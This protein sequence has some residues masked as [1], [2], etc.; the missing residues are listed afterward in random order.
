MND[1]KGSILIIDD[2]PANLRLLHAMLA[3]A[4]FE[5]RVATGGRPA[6]RSVEA[7]APDLILLDI[8]MPDLSGY[9]VCARLKAL[10]ATSDIPVL[11]ISAARD[12]SAKVR[13]FQVGGADYICK[14]FQVEEVLAR[15]R[16]HLTIHAQRQRIEEQTARLQELDS[17]KNRLFTDLS[18]EFRTPLM[19][20]A[21]LIADVGDGVYGSLSN[22]AQRELQRA[23]THIGGLTT[24]VEQIMDLSRLEAGAVR[25]KVAP[26]D[27]LSFAEVAALAF[28]P[29]AE[30]RG[31]RLRTGG[32]AVPLVAWFDPDALGKVL[33]NLLA[34]ALKHTGQGGEVRVSVEAA[35]DGT[36]GRCVH[37]DNTGP[38]IAPEHLP[39]LFD[40]FYHYAP[41]P[42]MT[43]GFGIGLAL[44]RELMALHH[45][46]LLAENLPDYGVR[47]TVM[48]MPGRSHFT[49]EELGGGGAGGIAGDGAPTLSPGL[50]IL[51]PT[52]H[53]ALSQPA[54]TGDDAPRPDLDEPGRDQPDEDDRTTLLVV[55][56]HPEVRRYLR[57]HLSAEYAVIEAADGEEGLALARSRLPDLI[58]SDVEM[59]GMDGLALCRAVKEDAEIGFIPVILLTVRAAAEEKLEGLSVGAD[60]YLAK[61]FSMAELL[62]R[63]ANLITSRRRLMLQAGE[64]TPAASGVADLGAGGEAFS[65]DS[66]FVSRLHDAV[67]ERMS[68]PD[69]SVEDLAA[70]LAQDRTTLYRWLRRLMNQSPS[71]VI[72]TIRLRRAAALLAARAGTVS[73]VAYGVGFRSVQ[74]FDRL[75]RQAYGRTPSQYMTCPST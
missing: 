29:A 46:Q 67:T 23:G 20:A 62:A 54:P 55:D 65:A 53:N 57:T 11:F 41:Q 26:A 28:A 40:R 37:V 30:R 50:Q 45:G 13:S 19:L 44:S 31:V 33:A 21:G 61:P 39:H 70:A 75:F 42:G 2:E 63:V 34:N 7:E 36:G 9:E 52:R 27:V 22:E 25:L 66:L 51:L 10:P 6:L 60:D 24:L 5:V 64:R 17:L 16:H 49:D 43:R 56:D 72:R 69:F 74:H 32:S 73:E 1:H 48:L 4:G 15:V 68:D 59:P 8:D 47:F 12:A 71:E 35:G 58:I 38:D 14:P 3:E 18:H